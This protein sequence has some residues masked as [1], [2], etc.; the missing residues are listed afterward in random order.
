VGYYS[1]LAMQMRVLRVPLPDGA[2]GVDFPA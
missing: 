2:T 1:L